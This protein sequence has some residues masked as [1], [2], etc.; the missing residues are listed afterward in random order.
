M[1]LDF[2]QAIK[3][4]V[5]QAMKECE[6]TIGMTLKEAI[7]KQIPKKPIDNRYPWAICSVCGGSVNLEN[8]QEYIQNNENT[9]CEHCGQKIDW[10]DTE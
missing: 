9:Y 2:E 1:K 10:G 4:G 8:V 5:D 6:L 7:E 3:S